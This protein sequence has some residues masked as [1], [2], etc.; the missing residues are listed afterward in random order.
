MAVAIL[1]FIVILALV[2]SSNGQFIFSS[3]SILSSKVP[4]GI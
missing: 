1:F 4:L 3:E 2:F